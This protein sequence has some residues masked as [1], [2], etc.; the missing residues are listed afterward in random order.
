VPVYCGPRGLT[1]QRDLLY[2]NNKDGTFTEVGVQLGIDPKQY[3]GLGVIWGDYDNDGL[4]DLYIANDSTA[5]LLYHNITS[6]G[7]PARFEEIALPAGVA[8][9]ADGH[10]QAG[11]G[12]DFGDYDADGWM[13]LIKT[14]FSD[15]APNVYHNNRDGTFTDLTFE[16]G[17]GEISRTSLGFGI[18]FADLE[19]SG[20]LDIVVANG[21][22]NPQV[23][24]QPMGISYAE[25]NFLFRNLG[26]GRFRESGRDAGP[27]FSGSAVNRGLAL[28]DFDNDGFMDLIFTRL[29][30]SPALLH[31][32]S[33]DGE[34]TQHHW[35]GMKLEGTRSNR[36]GFGARVKVTQDGTTQTREV[37]SNFSYLSASDPR[38]HFGFGSNAHSVDI[39]VRWPSG[40]VDT[41]KNIA[42]DRFIALKEGSS[43]VSLRK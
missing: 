40:T 36:D 28:I 41:I 37:R 8:Y 33:A 23:D 21:H 13:D 39:E 12:V 31:N 29:D 11:M 42:V 9:S 3:Y 10:E 17:L 2:H 20:A 43:P 30:A 22:V 14:N 26:N 32:V 25:R 35:L 4:L 38:P 6:P 7:G 1:G 19:N 15:D 34:T 5:N 16:S 24:R 18:A 27:G